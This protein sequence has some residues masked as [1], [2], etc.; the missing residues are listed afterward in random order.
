MAPPQYTV[1]KLKRNG[2]EEFLADEIKNPG[3]VEYWLKRIERDPTTP[4]RITWDFFEHVF[5]EEYV[6][7]R[8]REAKRKQFTELRQNGRPLIEYRQDYDHLA[9][10]ATD[11]VNNTTRR[12]EKFAEGLDHD[13]GLAMVTVDYTTFNAVYAKVE[14]AEER[15]AA[16]KVL[17]KNVASRTSSDSIS[18]PT[19]C[20]SDAFSRV[21]GL[22]DGACY[23]AFP[24][25]IAEGSELEDIKSD[26][27]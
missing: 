3:K 8:Y 5:E 25:N 15:I 9:E 19:S 20:V 27:H 1:E 11:L 24:C 7:D 26:E 13:L 17:E 2:A 16:K 10:Y 14:R 21:Q 4:E 23:L 18:P 12:C 22:R 6:P